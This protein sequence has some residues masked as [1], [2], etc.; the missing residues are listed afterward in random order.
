MNKHFN[1]VYDY[2]N[3]DDTINNILDPSFFGK[4]NLGKNLGKH[5]FQNL[6]IPKKTCEKKRYGEGHAA[7][8]VTYLR[9]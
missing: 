7:L 8:K 6:G 1:S 3:D 9:D 5:D 4:N 2:Y